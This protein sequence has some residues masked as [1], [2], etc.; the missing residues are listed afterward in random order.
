MVEQ[1]KNNNMK[2]FVTKRKIDF[3]THRKNLSKQ[4]SPIEQSR[5]RRGER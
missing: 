4:N 1:N 5:L 2:L 3:C